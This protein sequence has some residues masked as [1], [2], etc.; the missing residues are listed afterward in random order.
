VA[1]QLRGKGLEVFIE[2]IGTPAAQFRVA[3]GP[4]DDRKR[5]EALIPRIEAAVPGSGKPFIRSYP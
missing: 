2:P 4:E 3:V 1:R 5:A